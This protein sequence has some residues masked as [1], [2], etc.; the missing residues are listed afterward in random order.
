MADY[1]YIKRKIEQERADNN[2]LNMKKKCEAEVQFDATKGE[3]AEEVCRRINRLI[4]EAVRRYYERPHSQNYKKR[5]R[6]YLFCGYDSGVFYPT[7]FNHENEY[8]HDAII[9]I[10]IGAVDHQA[11][12]G[13]YPPEGE[14]KYL[15]GKEGEGYHPYIQVPSVE[16]MKK[17]EIIIK[18]RLADKDISFTIDGKNSG[19]YVGKLFFGRVRAKLGKL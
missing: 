12:R 18:N 14:N 7:I 4:E 6:K 5:G 16:A 17:L 3:V 1:S 2:A 8:F 19:T 10:H 13:E 9:E 15:C 11:D